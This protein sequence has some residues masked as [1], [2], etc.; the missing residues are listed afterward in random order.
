[1][2][3]KQGIAGW[4]WLLKF[5][6]RHPRLR[7]LKPQVTSAATVKGCTKINVAM[8]EPLLRLINFS[9]HRLLNY[10]ETGLN[11]LQLKVCKVISLKGKR[12]I[13]LSSAERGSIVTN[14]ACMNAT[15]T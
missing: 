8:F 7:L 2:L 15:V 10:E 3:V 12:K 11:V 14:V 13:S 5:M 6:Y 4:K 9:S 1:L